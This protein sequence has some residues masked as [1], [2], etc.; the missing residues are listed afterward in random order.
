MS[1]GAAKYYLFVEGFIFINRQRDL[2][3][4][5]ARKIVATVCTESAVLTA[6]KA[7]NNH[8]QPFSYANPQQQLYKDPP[9]SGLNCYIHPAA[10]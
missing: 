10:L 1:R 8:Q 2:Y 4:P 9:S 6:R 5:F 3:G 7:S